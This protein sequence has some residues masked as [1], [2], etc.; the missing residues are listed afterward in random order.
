MDPEQL[1]KTIY[2]GDR[3]VK[4]VLIDSW[5]ERVAIQVDEISRLRPGS[6]SWDFYTDEDISDGWLVF[7][8][9]R[10]IV[11]DPPGPLPDDYIC[12][13][14]VVGR[15]PAENR[16]LYSFQLSTAGSRKDGS[17]TAVS[18]RILAAGMHLEDPSRPGVEI[19]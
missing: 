5:K 7:T 11:F 9:V 18:I 19:T 2:L 6:T 4:A 3:A 10:E 14:S 12:G 16:D 8:G 13:L 15:E 17:G 1:I